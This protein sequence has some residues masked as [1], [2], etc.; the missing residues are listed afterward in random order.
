MVRV[1]DPGTVTLEPRLLVSPVGELFELNPIAP[2]KPRRPVAVIVEV[3]EPPAT[4]AT[5]PGFAY[6]SKSGPTNTSTVAY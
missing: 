2:E 1:D 4:I 6:S 5:K 3:H